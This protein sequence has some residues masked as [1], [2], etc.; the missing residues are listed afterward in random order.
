MRFD[1]WK[2]KAAPLRDEALR[3]NMDI[4]KFKSKLKE[5]ERSVRNGQH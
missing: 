1:K 3:A 2:D 4:D 5:I